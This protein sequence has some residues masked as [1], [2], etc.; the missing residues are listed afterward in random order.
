MVKKQS[1]QLQK[2][3][4]LYLYELAAF[5]TGRRGSPAF[6]PDS[7]GASRPRL[8]QSCGCALVCRMLLKIAGAL[9]ATRFWTV[10]ATTPLFVWRGVSEPSDTM[11]SGTFLRFAGESW[12]P[13]RKN[14]KVR[15]GL[16]LP[17]LRM[18]HTAV[19]GVLPTS[20]CP[21]WPG[22]PLFS[23]MWLVQWQLEEGKNQNVS[24]PPCSRNSAWWPTPTARGLPSGGVWKPAADNCLC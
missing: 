17:S 16:V 1:K 18:T 19:A 24:T 13:S 23:S 22:L 15:P 8:R 3:A 4:I 14:A 11:R 9:D 6:G 2:A 12:A 5:Y 7:H 10:S 21:L 20:P